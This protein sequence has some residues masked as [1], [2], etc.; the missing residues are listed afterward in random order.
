MPNY[1][2]LLSVYFP[3]IMPR[4]QRMVLSKAGFP[5]G[6]STHHLHQTPLRFLGEIETLRP[7]SYRTSISKWGLRLHSLHSPWDSY[8]YTP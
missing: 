3:M 8:L 7:L 2:L 1:S 4:A 5:T 6:L